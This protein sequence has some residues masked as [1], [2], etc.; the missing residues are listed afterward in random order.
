MNAEDRKDG[1]VVQLALHKY[2]PVQLRVNMSKHE[3]N[4]A[5]VDEGV[6]NGAS[7]SLL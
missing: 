6:P 3:R 7:L 4:A 5:G 1:R 2:L